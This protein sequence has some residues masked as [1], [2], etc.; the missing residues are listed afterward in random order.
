MTGS[1]MRASEG[2]CGQNEGPGGVLTTS[3]MEI[4][5]H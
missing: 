4:G 1:G 3:P 2:E 5:F